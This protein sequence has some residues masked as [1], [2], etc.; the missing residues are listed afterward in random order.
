VIVVKILQ[1]NCPSES[2]GLEDGS[3]VEDLF[4]EADK[5]FVDGEVTRRHTRLNLN[6][7]LYDND[8]VMISKMTKGN[9]DLFEVEILRIG[10]GGR[11]LTLTAQ[12]GYTIKQVLDQLPPDDR[13][14]FFRVD[15]TSAYEYRISGPGAS[16]D[17]LPVSY[18][19]T[20]APG[21]K[22][23]LL[24]SQLVKGN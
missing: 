6:D 16:T 21:S 7:R 12:P 18:V 9:Q 8:V 11:V 15:G 4:N 3:T 13:A 22:I 20:A 19:L 2:Y 14:Q 24:C 17:P 10:G 1:L 5:E 23:R